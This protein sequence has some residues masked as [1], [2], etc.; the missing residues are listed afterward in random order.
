MV[1][2]KMG[3]GLFRRQGAEPLFEDDDLRRVFF[4]EPNEQRVEERLLLLFLHPPLGPRS[5]L[6]KRRWVGGI[7][8]NTL[9]T[10]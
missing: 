4:P 7:R 6:R 1:P 3:S 5:R 10:E 9:K 8:S 2:E